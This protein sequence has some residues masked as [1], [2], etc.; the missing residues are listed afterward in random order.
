MNV[1]FNIVYESSPLSQDHEFLTF[2]LDR[3]DEVTSND[4]EIEFQ[5]EVK[6][7]IHEWI[8]GWGSKY[9]KV[10]HLQMDKRSKEKKKNS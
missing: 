9:L 5:R 6:F 2:D 10:F 7:T 1:N 8:S 4:T 3:N